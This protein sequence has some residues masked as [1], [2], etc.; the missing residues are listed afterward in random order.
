MIL[1]NGIQDNYII[2]RDMFVPILNAVMVYLTLTDIY[3]YLIQNYEKKLSKLIKVF[4]YLYLPYLAVSLL[5]YNYYFD[6]RLE[7]ILKIIRFNSVVN[8]ILALL[9]GFV[10]F[11]VRNKSK[12]F[13]TV[14]RA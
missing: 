6:S 9:I 4:R 7:N 11:K 8:V 5:I 13:P 3:K 2:G 14:R 12:L 1:L 10:I